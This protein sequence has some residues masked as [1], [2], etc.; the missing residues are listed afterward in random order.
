MGKHRQPL[1]CE[2]QIHLERLHR[3]GR[4]WGALR[5]GRGQCPAQPSFP[6]RSSGRW[7]TPPGMGS[8]GT[9][10][11]ESEPRVQPTLLRHLEQ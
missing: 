4:G 8:T 11:T 5:G 9:P 3:S 10:L 7:L 2:R 6:G 1:P